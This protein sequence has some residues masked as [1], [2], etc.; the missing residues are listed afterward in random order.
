MEVHS[1][2]RGEALWRTLR[3][4]VTHNHQREIFAL[5]LVDLE[6]EFDRFRREPQAVLAHIGS[7]GLGRPPA[8]PLA[9]AA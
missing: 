9:N 1:Y 6:A 8:P 3:K 7:P 5:L 4:A 2:G